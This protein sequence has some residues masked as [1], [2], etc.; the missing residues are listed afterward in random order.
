MLY[1]FER[2]GRKF[3]AHCDGHGADWDGNER[4]CA[5]DRIGQEKEKGRRTQVAVIPGSFR[6]N[7]CATT[8]AVRV[9]FHSPATARSRISLACAITVFIC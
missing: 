8:T 7:A 9:F 3:T 5:H 6:S 1:G 4:R 2:H